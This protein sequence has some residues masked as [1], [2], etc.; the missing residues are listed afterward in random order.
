M[1]TH[2]HQILYRNARLRVF[3]TI[4]SRTLSVRCGANLSSDGLDMCNTHPGRQICVW[5]GE[6]GRR[7]KNLG[8]GSILG[9]SWLSMGNDDG[10]AV[11]Q[12]WY[13]CG[14]CSRSSSTKKNIPKGSLPWH[15]VLAM[16][17]TPRGHH[18]LRK[19]MLSPQRLSS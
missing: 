15:A 14:I 9:T 17:R 3:H 6:R 13:R 10:M 18:M 11:G 2:N 8:H 4:A 12:V 16:Q 5:L 1:Y 19:N 7:R